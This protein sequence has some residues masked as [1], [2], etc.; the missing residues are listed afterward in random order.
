M[1][2][3]PDNESFADV[4]DSFDPR[5]EFPNIH[6]LVNGMDS[7]MRSMSLLYL[8]YLPPE[9]IEQI[10]ASIPNIIELTRNGDV[11]GIH[12]LLLAF[13]CDEETATMI[14]ELRNDE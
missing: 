12:A 11:N 13:G 10:E 6:A 1:L 9:K 7:T 3:L 2:P 14:A 5:E 4:L 8:T